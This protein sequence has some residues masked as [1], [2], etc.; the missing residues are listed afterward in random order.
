MDY[1]PFP[2]TP[3]LSP[4]ERRRPLCEQSNATYGVRGKGASET[5]AVGA[6]LWPHCY[7]KNSWALAFVTSFTGTLISFATAFPAR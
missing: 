4:R 2:L 3:A 6:M 7:F 1:T 5:Q